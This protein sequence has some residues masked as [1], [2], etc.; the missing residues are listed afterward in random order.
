MF[1]YTCIFLNEC[2]KNSSSAFTRQE[3]RQGIFSIFALIVL[4]FLLLLQSS[5]YAKYLKMAQRDR[6]I[7]QFYLYFE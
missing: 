7:I 1:I 6:E 4:M 3:P 5:N 2:E